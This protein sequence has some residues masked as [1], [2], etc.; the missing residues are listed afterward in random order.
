MSRDT[1]TVLVIAVSFIAVLAVVTL[2]R[3]LA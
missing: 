3:L 2:I 1:E